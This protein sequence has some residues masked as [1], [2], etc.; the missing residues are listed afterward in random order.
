ML[1]YALTACDLALYGQYEPKVSKLFTEG[2]LSKPLK[3]LFN[4]CSIHFQNQEGE[5]KFLIH[6]HTSF[7]YRRLHEYRFVT[8]HK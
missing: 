5:K 3:V 7:S 8:Y 2:K 6:L 4:N 1:W